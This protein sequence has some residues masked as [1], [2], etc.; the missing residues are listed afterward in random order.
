MA[1]SV[2]AAETATLVCGYVGGVTL[3]ICLVPQLFV[4]WRRRSADDVALPWLILYCIG[5]VKGSGRVHLGV[6][7]L[8]A[9]SLPA[10]EQLGV[11]LKKA[12][13]LA[14]R[15]TGISAAHAVAGEQ[16]FLVSA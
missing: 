9:V 3:A 15:W 5:R 2:P 8:D 14:E 6:Q 11:A 4:M 10:D 12:L 13:L 16:G 1:E 7:G